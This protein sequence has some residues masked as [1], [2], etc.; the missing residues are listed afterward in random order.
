MIVEISAKDKWL[1]IYNTLSAINMATRR[2]IGTRHYLAKALHTHIYLNPELICH[3]YRFEDLRFTGVKSPDI[4]F[5]VALER[6]FNELLRIDIVESFI[7]EKTY[8]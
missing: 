4:H 5:A 6:A 7:I 3:E 1:D 8:R 2:M